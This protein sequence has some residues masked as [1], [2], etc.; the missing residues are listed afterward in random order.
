MEERP[1]LYSISDNVDVL[2]V[3]ICFP[4]KCVLFWKWLLFYSNGYWEGKRQFLIAWNNE[5]MV[6]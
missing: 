5:W 1:L 2:H 3:N 6:T 4:P